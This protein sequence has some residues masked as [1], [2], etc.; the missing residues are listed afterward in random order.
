[1]SAPIA[2]VTGGSSGIGLATVRALA[3][4]G[5]RVYELSRR[6]AGADC[7]IHLRA[8]VTDEQSLL[9][10][11]EQVVAREGRIDILT[12]CAG[13][14]I[15]GAVEFTTSEDAHRQLEVNFFGTV[16]A[17][18]AVLPIMRRQRSGRI[19][20]ISSVAAVVPIPFQAYYSV[21]KAAINAFVMALRSE[22][23]PFGISVCAV[24]PGDIRTGFTAARVKSQAGDD[25]YGGRISRSVAVM[26]HD[27][28][29]GM[30]PE[31][32]GSSIA[33]TALARCVPPLRAI[34]A[35]YQLVH[36][37]SRLVPS[38]LASRI[39]GCIYGK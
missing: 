32:A 3:K 22:V 37:A 15:S 33:R 26:E 34:G 6:E 9:Q 30:S 5:C 29:T 21:S 12:C 16:N 38:A 14:G 24:M 19:V 36:T 39:I 17:C 35:K 7:A 1:M 25:E 8:D 13:Y 20:C 4:K 27:E 23:R 28:Q 2:V 31:R 11:I 10:A 18:R